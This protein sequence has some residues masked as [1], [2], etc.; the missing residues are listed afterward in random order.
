MTPE[1]SALLTTHNRA[2]LLPRVLEGLERQ[3]LAPSRFEVVVVDDGSADATPQVL[4]AWQNRLPLRVFRQNQAGLAA[5]K[6]LGVFAAQGPILVFLD[7]DDVA[8]QDLLAVH[9]AVHLA[10]PEQTV[11]VLGNTTLAPEIAAVPVMRH[12]TEVGCQLFSYGWMQPGQVLDHTAFWGGRSSCKRSLLVRHG[13]FHPDFHF[14]C[15]DIELGWRLARQ[16]LRVIYE[17]RA[18]SVMIRALTFDQFCARSY[19]QGRSQHRFARLHD[20]PKVRAYC[21]IDASENA[22][23]ERRQGYAAH[24]RW[25]RKLDRLAAA[26]QAAGLPAHPLL[27]QTLDEAYREAFFLS[28]AKGVADAAALTPAQAAPAAHDRPFCLLECGLTTELV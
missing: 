15:E 5:A 14:G 8:E 9:L 12:V 4:A 26:R 19:R 27:Q 24:L 18:R 11:A 17:P 25:T 20:D 16:G 21:E 6:N 2:H 3:S 23:A 22:W 10:A 13:V 28:R 1:I 7:D